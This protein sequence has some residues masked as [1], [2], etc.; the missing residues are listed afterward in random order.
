MIYS[1]TH[2]SFYDSKNAPFLIEL[3]ISYTQELKEKRI[4]MRTSKY[5]NFLSWFRLVLFNKMN[6][7]LDKILPY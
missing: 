7:I 5:I 6:V 1:K 3:N 2:S 4:W